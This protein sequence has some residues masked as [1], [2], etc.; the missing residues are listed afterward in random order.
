MGKLTKPQLDLLISVNNGAGMCA[1]Y[2]KPA[3]ALVSKG[4]CV[5]AT[6]SRLEITD[7]GRAALER[8]EGSPRPVDMEDENV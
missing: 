2:Y 4:Y 6:M 8:S 5:W 7:A 1:A 3:Q